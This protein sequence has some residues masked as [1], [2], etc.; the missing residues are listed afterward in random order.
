MKA[1]LQFIL[2]FI[3]GFSVCAEDIYESN[4]LGMRLKRIPDIYASE[5]GYALAVE[6]NENGET[7]TLYGKG[8]LISVTTLQSEDDLVTE[9]TE[10]EG[11]TERTVRRDGVIV[12]ET[13]TDA[14][15]IQ[16]R[17]EYN[18]RDGLLDFT[19]YYT[20]NEKE[21]RDQYSYTAD[22]RLLD[23][24]RTYGNGSDGILISFVFSDGSLSRYWYSG[25]ER[26]SY[27]RFNKKGIVFSELTAPG[28]FRE[29]REYRYSDSGGMAEEIRNLKSGVNTELFY[30][31]E[32]RIIRSVKSDTEGKQIEESLWRYS[33]GLLVEFRTR[34]E[35]SLEIFRY[36]YYP[37]E[38]LKKETYLKN[39][40]TLQVTDYSDEN[41]YSET[42]FR[43][44]RPALRIDYENGM[45]MKTVE[46][47]D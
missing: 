43:S 17:T 1:V 19:D 27:I 20:G 47:Q 25:T 15:G 41:N 40:I 21:Y 3:F 4:I 13:A 31:A 29:T 10:R 38:S 24:R 37:D 8:E 30:D 9:T 22:G 14:D 34:K 45:R 46:L 7:R 11:E 2:L 12:S 6:K 36:E 33:D 39:G 28:D 32:R 35:L 44:G 5:S 18:Y 26:K 16:S 42:L 23:V